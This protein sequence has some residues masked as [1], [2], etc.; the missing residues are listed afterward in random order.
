M[1]PDLGTHPPYTLGTSTITTTTTTRRMSPPPLL[2]RL[3]G[4][5]VANR[6][7]KR[8]LL[9]AINSIAALSIF[10]FG[11]DQG[12]MGG[13]NTSRDYAT[14]MGFA[15]V[16]HDADGTSTLVVTDALRKGGIVSVYYLGTLLGCLLGGWVGDAVGRTRTIALGAA[17]AVVGASLQC[18]AQNHVW[19]I[20]GECMWWRTQCERS[21]GE[22]YGRER[23]D[24]VVGWGG[25]EERRPQVFEQ[26]RRRE[27][28]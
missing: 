16:D 28:S 23:G 8:A 14:L 9:A 3:P 10:F 19:M 22:G 18:S 6:L 15:R 7:E 12:M 11:Y 21:N 1:G 26:P 24:K 4:A 17:W 27:W 5:N 25:D 20:C 2:Q 13:V